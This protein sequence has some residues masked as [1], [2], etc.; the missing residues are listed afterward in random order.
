MRS[1]SDSLG[2]I[3]IETDRLWGAQTQRSLENF[4]IGGDRYRWGRAV[5]EA[6]GIVKKAAALANRELGELSEE[7]CALI[8]AAADEVIAGQLDD[9]FPLVV[10]QTGSGTHTNMNVNEVI[11]NRAIQRAGGALGSKDPIH[12]NDHVNRSQSSNDVF[13]TVM[14]LAIRR[15]LHRDLLPALRD[16][17]AT[18][19][20]KADAHREL[21]KTGRTHLQDATPISL[22]QQISGWVT[23]LDEVVAGI[24]HADRVLADLTLGGTAVGTGLNAPDAF[25]ELAVSRIVEETG[26]D[27][28]I[29]ANYFAGSSAHDAVVA[30]SATL[31]TAAVALMKIGN[32]VRWL[33]SGPRTGIGE[34]VIPSNEPG[35]SIMPGKV[36]PSQIE[37]LTMIA[38]HVFGNDAATAFAGSQGNFEL[39]AYKPVMLSSVLDSIE[40]LA[41]GARSFDQRCARGIEPNIVRIERNLENNLMLVTALSPQIGYDRAAAIA[42][43]AAA[44]DISLRQAAIESGAVDPDQFDLWVDPREMM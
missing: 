7:R 12:P 20:S 33:A 22:G 28:T 14:H 13:P 9:H 34:L 10:W 16:V 15:T 8:V 30:V 2:T 44:R 40:L 25:A 1:E 17:G 5:I 29:R 35:S 6:L 26:L 41:D 3:E 11:A 18:L 36:N 21:I 31:R 19:A 39:N 43:D 42:K 4:P 24:E 23:Q 38:V 27:W 37:A 32:D